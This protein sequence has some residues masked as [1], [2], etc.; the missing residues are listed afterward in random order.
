MSCGGEAKKKHETVIYLK[1]GKRG[2]NCG[3]YLYT[4]CH[5]IIK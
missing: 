4:L 5:N 3:D 2:D 1:Y